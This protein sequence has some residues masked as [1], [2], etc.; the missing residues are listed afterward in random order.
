MYYV[1]KFK[2][3]PLKAGEHE[4]SIV[5]Y[6]S[7]FYAP[8]TYLC[9]PFTSVY[10]LLP[11]AERKCPMVFSKRGCNTD[12]KTQNLDSSSSTTGTRLR[13]LTETTWQTF[14]LFQ[15]EN[16]KKKMVYK[17]CSYVKKCFLRK[18]KHFTNYLT[19]KHCQGIWKL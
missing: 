3:N 12:F 15:L 11:W 16:K 2:A 14:N 10:L 13:L 6:F 8:L 18:S 4:L 7:S 1:L 17:V 9:V 19:P 5:Y